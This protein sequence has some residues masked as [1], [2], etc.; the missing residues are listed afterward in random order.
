MNWVFKD[1]IVTK[2][3]TIYSHYIGNSK[4]TTIA[5]M[6]EIIPIARALKG[7]L[8]TINGISSQVID[9]EISQKCNLTEMNYYVNILTNEEFKGQQT[10]FNI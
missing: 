7:T 9:V 5:Q 4:D 6:D 3:G 8:I 1:R 10:D 2:L